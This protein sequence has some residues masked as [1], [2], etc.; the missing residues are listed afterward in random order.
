ATAKLKGD[1]VWSFNDGSADE[2]LAS[3]NHQFK[4]VG[5]FRVT[6]KVTNGANQCLDETMVSVIPPSS[7]NP[8]GK[9]GERPAPALGEALPKADGS[10][11]EKAYVV[12]PFEEMG[13]QGGSQ[14]NL[15]YNVMIPYNSLNAQVIQKLE[16]KPPLLDNSK[17]AVTYS[18]AS[19][20]KDP[21]GSNSINSTSANLFK[22]QQA[23]SNFDPGASQVD[24]IT[25]KPIKNEFVDGQDYRQAS[26]RKT[27]QWDRMKQPLAEALKIP[28][29]GLTNADSQSTFTPARDLAKVDQG[30]RG[31]VDNGLGMRQMPGVKNPYV[32]NDPQNFDYSD[33]QKSFVAQFIP[34]SDIDDKGRANPYPL[35]R[36]EAKIAD[37][38]VAKTDAVFTTA[39]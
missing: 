11:D 5:K 28:E 32:A 17:L 22:N 12:L 6:L 29:T 25:K 2:K 27:E 15:P 9:V 3:T 34:A 36:V 10:N 7:A 23:G 8:N 37:K 26:I 20:A 1:Y 31:Y 16:H 24:P 33:N 19:N 35:M 14:V 39:S 38:V 4:D 18:A 21:S 13:M 30:I